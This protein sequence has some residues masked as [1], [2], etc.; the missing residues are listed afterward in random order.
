MTARL[1]VDPASD[2]F[3]RVRVADQLVSLKALL[4]QTPEMR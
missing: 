3:A 4:P 2:K 1:P